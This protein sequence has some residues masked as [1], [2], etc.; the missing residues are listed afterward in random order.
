LRGEQEVW[1]GSLTGAATWIRE[2][3]EAS[4]LAD[5][6]AALAQRPV[7][8]NAPDISE[9]LR[10]LDAVRTRVPMGANP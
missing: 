10:R 6:V 2:F 1:A 8:V 4:A 9:P 7:R 5:D 3:P